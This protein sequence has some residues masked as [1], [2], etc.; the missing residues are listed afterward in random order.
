MYRLISVLL[1]MFALATLRTGLASEA[2]GAKEDEHVIVLDDKNFHDVVKQHPFIVVEFY[3]PWCGHCKRLAPEYEKA[4]AILKENDPPIILANINA[5]EESNRGLAGE[6][7]V[8]GFPTLKIIENGGKIIRDYKGPR[9]ADGIVSYLKKQVGPPSLEITTP[10]E[11]EKSVEEAEILVV[12]VFNSYDSD[13]YKDFIS[14]ASEL[15]SEYVFKHTLDSSLLPKKD[16]DLS[17]PSI[18]VFKKFDEGFNDLKD[19]ASE[20]VKKF[21]EDISIPHVVLFNKDPVQRNYLS[22]IFENP[23]NAKAFLFLDAK[24]DA[25]EVLKK[26]YGELAKENK[27]KSVRFMLAD[28]EDGENA[29]QYFGVKQD[30]L[31]CIVIQGKD[32]KKYLL[33]KASTEN[34]AAWLKD[35]FD[36][37]AL[38]FL[39]SEPV[40]EKN[41]EPVKV[42][43]LDT[44]DEIVF[45]SGKNVLLEFYAP[46]CGHC[47]NLAPILDE[48]AIALQSDSSVVIAKLDATANDIRDKR[49]DIQGFPTLY[50]HT[51]SGKV[52]PYDGNRTKE[53]LISFI[54]SNKESLDQ[55]MNESK[56]DSDTKDEL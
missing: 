45:K 1:F 43:V 11:G 37:K 13:E 12:G 17:L 3:A 7:G 14:V 24:D 46:W 5:D 47:K 18:R 19:F 50:F 35:Y 6:Y 15:R 52:V 38:E 56:L 20:A 4:A 53:D 16:L 27:G 9:D 41:D 42:V 39:K 48:V 31:P 26:A 44:L 21:L 49:F 29:M 34:M 30:K 40:P 54:N 22:K 32:Q 25:G 33:E 55:S 23:D 8:R 2:A 51:S 10:E 36:G 28:N